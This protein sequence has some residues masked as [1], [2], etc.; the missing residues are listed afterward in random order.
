[1][2]SVL[3]FLVMVA[4]L[5]AV[6]TR[7]DE[8]GD[9]YGAGGIL[10]RRN[11]SQ[12][13]NPAPAA[14]PES[15]PSKPDEAAK[16]PKPDDQPA[17]K[18][19]EQP[20]QTH[21]VDS[22][23]VIR[24]GDRATR[25]GRGPMSVGDQA[26]SEATAP[27]P[28]DS[29]KWFATI[30]VDDGE[31]SQAL[32]YDLKHSPYLRAWV[33]LDEPKESWSHATVYRSKDE[34]QH[35]R[36]S[37]LR[38]TQFPVLVIQPPAKLRDESQPESWIWGNPKTVV[39]QWDGY[40]VK[41]PNR[42]QL[43]SD[44]IRKALQL[45]VAKM[46]AKQPAGPGPRSRAAAPPATPGAKQQAGPAQ[47][48]Y[49]IN[50]PFSIPPQQPQPL[51]PVGPMFPSD[52]T[53]PVVPNQLP[54]PQTPNALSLLLMV[55]GGLTTGSGMTNFL[56]VGL[57]GVQLW[58]SFRKAKGLPTLLD[59]TQFARLSEILNALAGKPTP[60]SNPA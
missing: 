55:L 44:A 49:G 19:V 25:S 50:P 59:D 16:A 3:G 40:D 34:T 41:N 37:S 28:D 51:S 32:L 57:I 26:I 15:P 13:T 21:D 42:A 5:C 4:A 2:K 33:N 11:T 17:S 7:A 36:W 10:F 48:D 52:P 54:Q 12:P 9:K 43:R 47:N 46:S 30:I 22:A 23:E 45:Y 53:L 58:R 60:P 20:T 39:W 35:W 8:V 18:S 14:K 1:M 38:I 31:A 6:T 27:P 24:R 56:L 29:H